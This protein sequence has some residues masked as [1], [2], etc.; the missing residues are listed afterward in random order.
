L[1]D[2]TIHSVRGRRVWDSRGRPT[3]EAEIGL[4]GGATG[5]AIAPAG[6]STGSGEALDRR[7]GGAAHGGY[8]V[9]GAVA[10][11]ND[12]IGPA[13]AGLDAADQAA[14]PSAPEK[15]E[16][17]AAV[18]TA[19]QKPAPVEPV[20]LT[21]MSESSPAPERTTAALAPPKE[22]AAI[23]S[24]PP[25]AAA[26]AVS[27]GS[28]GYVVVL[29]SVPVSGQSRLS[30]LRKFADMQEKYGAVL[31]NKTPDVQE[32]NLGEKGSYHR[33]LV[34]P[35]GSRAQ[36]SSLCSDLKTAGYKDCWVTAY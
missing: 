32:A 2:T 13:L 36:A 30:A 27:S 10:A 15:P 25:P 3:V 7:D 18:K 22:T 5:R 8:D 28:N 14:K 6:A 9:R 20:V 26:P 16:V 19:P 29:A 1:S 24:R 11:V 12:A 33:L 21:T 35:P 31:Q 23:P 17:I 34:G 4:A